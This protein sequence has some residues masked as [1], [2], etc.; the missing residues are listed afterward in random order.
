MQV[1][2]DKRCLVIGGSGFIGSH[3]LGVLVPSG[4]SITSLD[5]SEVSA[6]RKIGGV[7]YVTGDYSDEELIENLLSEHDEVIHL[8]YASQPNTSFDDPFFDLSQNLPP[9]IQLFD[10]ASR[11]GV[12]VLFVSSGG[13]VYGE[14]IATPISEDHPTRPISPYGVTKLTL[15]KYAHFYAVTRGLNVVYVRPANPYGEGQRPFTGQGFISTA[16]ALALQGKPIDIYGKHGAVRDYIYID[17]LIEGIMTV[18]DKGKSNEV[19]NIGSSMGYSNLQVIDE[20]K[21]ILG[22]SGMGIEVCHK[23][24]RP[25]DVKVNILDTGK[26]K[27]LGWTPKVSVNQGML[28]MLRWL[29]EYMKHDG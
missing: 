15:E 18:L 11:Y 13:T 8:A 21:K 28:R 17:D 9:T 24:E 7:S 20:I 22:Y 23:L 19:Y 1:Q 27:S 29:Q 10:I 5:R 16:M 4:K 25:F 26:L 14:S 6:I 2:S 3:L 12:R